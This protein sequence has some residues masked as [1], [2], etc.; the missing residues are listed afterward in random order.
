M[1]CFDPTDVLFITNK[2]DTIKDE[3]GAPDKAEIAK[4]WSDIKSKLKKEWPMVKDE[5]IFQLS[6]TDVNVCICITTKIR[7]G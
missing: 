3:E 6:L 7:H 2:W 4:T 1:P 5:N